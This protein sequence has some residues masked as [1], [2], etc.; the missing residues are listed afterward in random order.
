MC[1]LSGKTVVIGAHSGYTRFLSYLLPMVVGGVLGCG[2]GDPNRFPVSGSVTLKGVP[3]EKG[4]I[5][6]IAVKEGQGAFRHS[7]AKIEAG[8]YEIPRENGLSPGTYRVL[9]SSGR[10]EGIVSDGPNQRE[11]PKPRETIPP[12]YNT[13]SNVTVEIRP[14][15]SNVCDFHIQ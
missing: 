5:Q 10:V 1:A 13:K 7:G 6:F 4:T 15:N 11:S 14:D 3:L 8:T 2:G 9:I 12:A